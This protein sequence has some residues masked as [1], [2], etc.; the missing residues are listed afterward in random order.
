MCGM[1]INPE[2]VDHTFKKVL[3]SSHCVLRV[4]LL[5]CSWSKHLPFVTNTVPAT[6]KGLRS[7]T[8]K[9]RSL[10]SDPSPDSGTCTLS[11]AVVVVQRA[12][13]AAL[14]MVS[15]RALSSSSRSSSRQQPS[16]VGN[17]Q[18]WASRQ[19]RSGPGRNQWTS[20]PCAAGYFTAALLHCSSAA[21][22]HRP[23]LLPVLDTSATAGHCR[24]VQLPGAGVCWLQQALGTRQGTWH[25][26]MDLTVAP[27]DITAPSDFMQAMQA[28]SLPTQ[29]HILQRH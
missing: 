16:T 22:L 10:P 29:P 23:D 20:L 26:P 5:A 3:V 18:S 8:S 1:S 28:Q 13:I 25:T 27:I 12:S 24:R 6:Q 2:H 17:S 9:H 7:A 11:W 4:G 14:S 21:A 19:A 15:L